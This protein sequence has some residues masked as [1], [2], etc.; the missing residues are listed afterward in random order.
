VAIRKGVV[1]RYVYP[2]LL[3]GK[4]DAFMQPAAAVRETVALEQT[5]TSLRSQGARKTRAE[6]GARGDGE[7]RD[8]RGRRESKSNLVG[9]NSFAL[10]M[11]K[12]II[13]K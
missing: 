12:C 5:T 7:G 6:R 11:S 4:T 13:H 8:R 1:R 9:E 2:A 10:H 3:R